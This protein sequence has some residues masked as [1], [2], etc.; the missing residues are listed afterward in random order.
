MMFQQRAGDRGVLSGEASLAHLADQRPW[1]SGFPSE[2]DKGPT[3]QFWVGTGEAEIQVLVYEEH[4]F[5]T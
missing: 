2:S 3:G 1:Q 4:A 5:C